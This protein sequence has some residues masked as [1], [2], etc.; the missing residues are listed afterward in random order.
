MTAVSE[1][2]RGALRP[3][4]MMQWLILASLVTFVLV[5]AVGVAIEL[6]FGQSATGV[7]SLSE[8]DTG[9]AIALNAGEVLEVRLS[10]NPTTGYQWLLDSADVSVL[11]PEGEPAYTPDSAL[12]GAGGTYTFRF[13]A[14]APGDVRLRLSYLRSWEQDTP[15]LRTFEVM[16][17]VK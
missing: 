5:L 12:L 11:K 9:K 3:R 10:G 13:T 4:T 1:P 8:R 15:P 14:V 7:I 16:V 17:T 6:I 2:R